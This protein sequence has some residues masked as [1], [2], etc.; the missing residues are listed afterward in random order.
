MSEVPTERAWVEF[1]WATIRVVPSVH[2]EEFVNVGVVL[3]AR[4]EEFL[5]AR[6]EVPWAR[7]DALA[8]D[9]D[10]AALERHLDVF[11]RV[12]RGEATAGEVALLPPSER[13]HWLT[14]PRSA[15]IQTS[16]RRPGRTHD[17][18]AELRR[19]FEEQ[20]R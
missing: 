13:F 7:L 6:V 1:E 18:P 2:R 8:S 19:L 14:A 5:E 9:L 15:V 4:R 3:H 20:C 16:A 11:Q 10:R 12:A 17:L